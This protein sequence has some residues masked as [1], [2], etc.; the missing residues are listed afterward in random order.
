MDVDNIQI[1]N[2][3]TYQTRKINSHFLTA[4]YWL[5]YVF[6]QN[7]KTCQHIKSLEIGFIL[8]IDLLM[9]SNKMFPCRDK[10]IKQISLLR[11]HLPSVET[12]LE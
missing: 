8:V 2:N 6:M 5:I 3:L 12:S 7:N 11:E 10:F 9:S 1:N 4:I